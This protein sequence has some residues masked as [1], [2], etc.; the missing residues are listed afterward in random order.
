MMKFTQNMFKLFVILAIQDFRHLVACSTILVMKIS[1]WKDATDPRPQKG[2]KFR[3]SSNVAK[4]E[5]FVIGSLA[6][7]VWPW[8]Y[9]SENKQN[10]P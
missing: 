4:M 5:V 7:S 9:T 10:V 3:S 1:Q 2:E 6:G 8:R